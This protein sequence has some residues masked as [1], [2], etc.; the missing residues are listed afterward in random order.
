[1]VLVL[2]TTNLRH[3]VPDKVLSMIVTRHDEE[4][5]RNQ[6]LGFVRPL[7]NKSHQPDHWDRII[8]SVW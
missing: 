7:E 2:N 5:R 3:Q 1:M 6:I 8:R 4:D